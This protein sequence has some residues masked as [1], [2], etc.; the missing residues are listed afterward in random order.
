MARWC[1]VFLVLSWSLAAAGEQCPDGFQ[2]PIAIGGNVLYGFVLRH[3]DKPPVEPVKSTKISVYSSARNKIY[4]AV[5]SKDGEFYTGTLPAG[6]YRIVVDGFGS[7]QV[8]LDPRIDATGGADSPFFT[9]WLVENGCAS[10]IENG[11]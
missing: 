1:V 6:D 11:N 9:L 5:T 3:A 8:K 4:A 7:Y 10:Y 2:N